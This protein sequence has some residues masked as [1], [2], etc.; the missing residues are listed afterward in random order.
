MV[1]Y[2]GGSSWSWRI[3]TLVQGFGPVLLLGAIVVPE[4]PRWLVKNGREHEAHETLAK[5]Q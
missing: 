2:P 1:Y 4:S 3:P 5:Y